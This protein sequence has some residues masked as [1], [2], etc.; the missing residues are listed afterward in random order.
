M[1]RFATPY[2]A[3]MMFVPSS[4]AGMLIPRMLWKS[5]PLTQD[6]SVLKL[7]KEVQL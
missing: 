1:I 6:V 3:F 4:L 7:S 2:L 5:F